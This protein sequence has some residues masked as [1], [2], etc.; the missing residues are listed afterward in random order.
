MKKKSIRIAIAV[1]ILGLFILAGIRIAA[2]IK[3]NSQKDLAIKKV[4]VIKTHKITKGQIVD[5]VKISGVIKPFNEIDIYPKI[6]GRM[7]SINFDIGDK[8]KAGDILGVIEHKELA[9][10]EKAASAA[11]SIAQ[12][13]EKSVYNDLERTKKLFSEQVVSKAHLEGI[14]LKFE[15]AQA[16]SLSSKAQRDIAKQQVENAFITSP[17]AGVITKKTITLGANVS[18]NNSVFSIQ[19]ISKLKLMTSVDANTLMNISKNTKAIL[20]FDQIVG[21]SFIGKILTI[22]PSLDPKSRRAAIEI[23]ITNPE[24][25]I[26]SNMFI[27]GFLNL[28]E[29]DN[30]LIIPNKGL[31]VLHNKIYIFKIVDN[32][33]NMT[34]P[35]LGL[36]DQNNSQVL[37]GLSEGDLIAISD[38][39]ELR[40]GETV[41]V[42]AGEQ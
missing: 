42:S 6:S 8:V 28:R 17:I 33:V 36:R 22:S 27:D 23:D 9:L 15:Q 21:K 18:P 39:S 41:E 14:E 19:D 4:L 40:D 25:K 35:K 10:Q 11:F 26:V 12:A 5:Q 16:Q 32:K 37:E 29:L 30:I 38:L 1:L 3:K 2:S 24:N 20:T 13:N 34:T 31:Y 7:T